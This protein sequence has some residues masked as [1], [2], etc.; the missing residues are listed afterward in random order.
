MDDR[1]LKMDERLIGSGCI[2]CGAESTTR[3]HVPS[4]VFLDKP[5]PLEFPVVSCCNDCNFSFSLDEQYLACLLDCV[6]CGGVED[7][8]Q[9]RRKVR[10]ILDEN[11]L[12]KN[13]I[14]NSHYIDSDGNILWKPEFDRVR[15][16]VIK[17]ARGHV[18]Y[19]LYPTYEEPSFVSFFPLVELD[20]RQLINFEQIGSGNL[21]GYPEIGSRAFMRI[22][23]EGPDEF[24]KE[25]DWVIVQNNRYRYAVD[26]SGF[27]VRMVLSEYLGCVVAWD[28]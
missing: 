16:I 24:V 14:E 23:G 18:S 11:T 21:V 10:R 20:E 28:F 15:N 7:S 5:Y 8:V 25:G 1:H 19:E 13:R 3:D 2:Y 17:L 12:L 9:S 4:K 26:E 22:V 6:I 27:E